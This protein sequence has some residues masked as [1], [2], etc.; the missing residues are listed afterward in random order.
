MVAMNSFSIRQRLIILALLA[1]SALL[2]VGG[3]SLVQM[4]RLSHQLD[5]SIRKHQL[6]IGAVEH[7]RSAQVHFKIQVQE[8]K[9][10]LLR[11]RNPADFDKY[12]AGFDKEAQEV[13]AELNALKSIAQQLGILDRLKVDDV[14]A[15]FAKLPPAYLEALKSYDPVAADPAG[16]VDKLVKGIDRAPTARIDGVVK[17][18]KR[19]ADELGSQELAAA[20]AI[21]DAVRTG[22][23]V[24]IGAT[25]FVLAGIAWL[26]IASVTRPLAKLEQTMNH[27][28]TANDLTHR[29]DIVARDE[30]GRMAA[31]FNHMLGKMQGMIG[32]VHGAASQVSALAVE[33]NN[34]AEHV[35]DSSATQSNATSSSAASVQQLTVSINLVAENADQVLQQ[36]Q[37]A[38]RVA[39]EGA[40]VAQNVSGNIRAIASSL[41]AATDVM[42]S[43]SRRSEE[44]GGIVGVIREI[45]DQTNLLAL[46]AAIEAA[47]AGETGRGFA[48]VADEVRKLAERTAQ[49]TAE[50]TAMIANVQQDTKAA[51]TGLSQ[52]RIRVEDGVASTMD[53]VK[54]LERLTLAAGEMVR[55][56]AEIN[57]ALKEQGQAS[58]EI[59]RNVENVT[60]QADANSTVSQSAKASAG[61]LAQVAE[62]LGFVVRQFR[63]A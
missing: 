25:A 23:F 39:G 53:V 35:A 26:I 43:L 31:A 42:A 47:R 38:E 49:A 36:S 16:T 60:R 46:N 3:F 27:I 2:G 54:V 52:A 34:A 18:I 61:A 14:L 57:H 40:G 50:I 29:V 56:A 44:I 10:I 41:G 45:A 58:T 5:E 20:K 12:R 13:V 4:A 19:V 30:I 9:N 51:D 8:W 15:E 32:Q 24:F 17:E 28:T 22:L 6:M 11:G 7:A 63:V 33:V 62:E 21:D 37:H 48:V 59:A 1:L 55:C